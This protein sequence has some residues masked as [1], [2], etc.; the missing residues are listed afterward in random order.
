M[1]QISYLRQR[2]ADQDI[3]LNI[4]ED[5]LKFIAKKGFD[6]VY[7]ARPLK[8]SIQQKLANPLAQSLLAG[9]FNA[10]DTIDVSLEGDELAFK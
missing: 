5:A 2:L 1:I 9:Q 10:G 8:R 7:G 4:S 3:H 6:P